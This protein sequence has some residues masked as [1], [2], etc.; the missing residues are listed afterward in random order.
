MKKRFSL[1]QELRAIRAGKGEKKGAEAK[2]TA[3]P[4]QTRQ[5]WQADIERV[6]QAMRELLRTIANLSGVEL[7]GLP[8]GL[9]DE[10]A[11]M[12]RLDI[13]TL[14]DR[15][16]NE[17]EGFSI[18]T[19]EEVSNRA[20]EQS[21]AVLEAI[22]NEVGGQV[23]Q[24]AAEFREKLQ[25]R[26]EPEQIEIDISKVSQDH[27]KKTLEASVGEAAAKL[28]ESFKQKLENLFAE[29]EKL[30]Q[31]R[32]QGVLTSAEAQISLLEQTVQQIYEIKA[33][34][35][36]QLPA[37]RP[38]LA[39]GHA[40]KESQSKPEVELGEV[41]GQAALAVESPPNKPSETHR[42]QPVPP[43]AAGVEKQSKPAAL[44]AED[45]QSRLQRAGKLLA[46][47]DSDNLHRKPL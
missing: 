40:T 41:P 42:K 23:D 18:K 25:R 11:P 46:G 43:A 28:E 36:A 24:V 37:E 39:V 19:A 16:R 30:V 20:R 35:V 9:Q 7:P 38:I 44:N 26:L 13:K 8:P 17:L 27:V 22:Q 29:Q 6:E 32:L 45:I 1:D 34:L 47:L 15:I 5:P 33:D 12:H 21:R 14:K 10:G 2:G 31:D 3:F 4:P